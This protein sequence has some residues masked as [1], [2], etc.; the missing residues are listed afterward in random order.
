MQDWSFEELG[1]SRNLFAKREL[2]LAR[3]RLIWQTQEWKKGSHSQSC[4]PQ[5][6]PGLE[7]WVWEQGV[8][9]VHINWGAAIQEYKRW[10][11]SKVGSW[12]VST[13]DIWVAS[14]PISWFPPRWSHHLAWQSPFPMWMSDWL[15]VVTFVWTSQWGVRESWW[16]GL[17]ESFSEQSLGFLSQKSWV[18]VWPLFASYSLGENWPQDEGN[19]E[20]M[21]QREGSNLHQPT[22]R[23]SPKAKQSN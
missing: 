2:S 1:P 8:C 22:P 21:M 3:R 10:A 15:K 23:A 16:S 7:R 12:K 20:T 14:Y 5:K 6:D 17:L 19:A 13:A 11:R 4:S 9:H 18:W